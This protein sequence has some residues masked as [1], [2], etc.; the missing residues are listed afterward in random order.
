LLRSPLFWI[1]LA[2]AGLRLAGLFWGLPASDGWDDD[3]F[4][5][6]NFLTALALTWKPGSYFTYPP[7]H[8][9]LL[10]IPALPVAGWALA[11]A[12]SL[13]QHDVIAAITQ[14]ATMTYFAVLGR[15]VNL[16]MSLGIIW[17]VG[18][19]ARQVAGG[20]LGESRTAQSKSRAG[21]LAAIA[22]ALNFGLTYYG[23]VSN[24]DVPYLFWAVLAL[25]WCMRAVVE[26][27]PR[28][29]WWAALFAA[30]AVATKDQAYA[31]FLL[32]L[33]FFLLLWFAVDA[34]PRAHGRQIARILLPAAAAS[35]FLLLL[36]D[37]AVTNP[38]GFLRRIAFLAGP[39]SQDYAEYLHGPSG[40]LALLGDM[41]RYFTQGYGLAAV[42]LAVLGVGVHILRSRGGARVAG[43]LPL[44][45]IISFTVC[46]NFAALRSD[47]RFLLPQAVLSCVYIGIAAEVLAFPM[48]NW[49]RLAG[50][51]VLALI[52]LAALH[53]AVAIN[54]A[55]LFDP[56][57]DAERWMTTHVAPGDVIETYGQNCFL[58]RF[59]KNARVIRVGQGSLKLRNPLPG[60]TEVREAFIA[61]R[62]PRFIVLSLAWARRYLRPAIPLAP[63][64][65]YSRLQQGD[66]INTD[67]HLFF[68]NLVKGTPGG[69]SGYR[70]VHTARPAGLWPIVHIHDSLDEP[71]WI[72]ERAS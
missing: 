55:F 61:Q 26:Q 58:P 52:A 30:A 41:A 24:L 32:S 17:C 1:L 14:P 71:V 20:A 16:M 18:E 40:W 39:A 8:A 6:R 13:S 54:A 34:W 64:H 10:A 46:F 7:L 42:T 60:V 57:Y 66:F 69:T 29:F 49:A 36:V 37:G 68:Q 59:P 44:L 72:F 53:Q 28:R 47:D 48:Q 50:R 11:H 3:G 22:C 65:I 4:A 19:M 5:P 43:L 70:L 45:A 35:L 31:L 12:P 62:H 2:A 25:L 27:E 23:Q 38:S 9:L 56:R 33:P 67:A 21:L 63:G 15:L 51:A